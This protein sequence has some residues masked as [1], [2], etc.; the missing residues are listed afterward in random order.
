MKCICP[1]KPCSRFSISLA[2]KLSQDLDGKLGYLIPV[3]PTFF[4]LAKIVKAGVWPVTMATTLL[5]PGGYQ[6]IKNTLAELLRDT[7]ISAVSGIDVQAITKI[8]EASVSDPHYTKSIKIPPVRKTK[9]QVPLVDCIFSLP[10]NRDV[11]FIRML[12]LK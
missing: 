8:A 6:A 3:V 9:S 10:V 5:K 7:G 2:A 12:P 1:G 4:N 11:Q